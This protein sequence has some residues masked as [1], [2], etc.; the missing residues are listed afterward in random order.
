MIRLAIIISIITYSFWWAFPKGTFYIGNAIV[1][2]LIGLH[3]FLKD[4]KSNTYFLLF[5]LSFNNILDEVFF[6][7]ETFGINEVFFTIGIILITII[8][9][10]KILT[11]KY[12]SS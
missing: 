1:F 12:L 6:D 4:K 7:N 3:L 10:S 8:R 11:L 2:F 5:A 9:C